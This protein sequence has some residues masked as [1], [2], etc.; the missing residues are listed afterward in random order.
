[1]LPPCPPSRAAAA[2]ARLLPFCGW[3]SHDLAK[4]A[5]L[6]FHGGN[7]AIFAVFLYVSYL[8]HRQPHVNFP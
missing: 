4:T 6:I 8:C 3:K 7:A 5:I 2:K 1:M